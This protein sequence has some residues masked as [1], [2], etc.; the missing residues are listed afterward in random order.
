M[1]DCGWLMQWF[2]MLIIKWLSTTGWPYGESMTKVGMVL[3]AWNNTWP[4]VIPCT[5]LIPEEATSD[6]SIYPW[7]RT[8][9]VNLYAREI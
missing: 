2:F 5:V 3:W 6:M 9:L 7:G 1:N 8:L 4:M